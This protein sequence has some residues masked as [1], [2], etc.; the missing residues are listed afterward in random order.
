[1]PSLQSNT[2]EYNIATITKNNTFSSRST[3]ENHH[4]G[5]LI[6]MSQT[7]WLLVSQFVLLLD[8]ESG[9]RKQITLLCMG[10][11]A[12][13]SPALWEYDTENHTAKPE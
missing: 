5:K 13:V 2:L 10:Q 8:L 7:S 3:M 1:M 11:V 4:A 9:L 6:I 12:T